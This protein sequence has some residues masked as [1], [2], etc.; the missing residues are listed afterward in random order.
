MPKEKEEKKEEDKQEVKPTEAQIV[1]VPTQFGIAFKIGN[2]VLNET[3]LLIRIFNDIQ[4][5]KK[6]VA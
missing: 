5:I 6:S 2:E 4:I 3:E 1:E